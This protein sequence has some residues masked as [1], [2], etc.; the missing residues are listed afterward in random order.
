MYRVDAFSCLKVHIEFAAGVNNPS[1]YGDYRLLMAS[2]VYF[3]TSVLTR[4]RLQLSE[5]AGASRLRHAM[6][7]SA[8]KIGAIP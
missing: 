5:S 8:E 1:A 4:W 6:E 2:N 7:I 3:H